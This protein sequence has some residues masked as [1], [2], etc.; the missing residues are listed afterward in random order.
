MTSNW[1]DRQLRRQKNTT[2]D[3]S[4]VGQLPFLEGK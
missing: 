3:K 4:G 2:N 1:L